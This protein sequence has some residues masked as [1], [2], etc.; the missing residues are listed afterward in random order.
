M[1]LRGI[2]ERL[3]YCDSPTQ[4]ITL[5]AVLDR[6]V[7]SK[8]V[9][10]PIEC[11]HEPKCP[12][13]SPTSG[14]LGGSGCVRKGARR[15]SFD[16]LCRIPTFTATAPEICSTRVILRIPVVLIK[17]PRPKEGKSVWCSVKLNTYFYCCYISYINLCVKRTVLL[18]YKIHT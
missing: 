12:S 18:S 8:T 9:F 4:L 14:D 13:Q 5:H 17:N 10:A 7:I 6:H 15:S 2:G 11:H 1:D 16:G 3:L